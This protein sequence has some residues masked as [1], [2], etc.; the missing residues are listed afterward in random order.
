MAASKFALTGLFL[1]ATSTAFAEE[2]YLDD[3]S[4]PTAVIRSYYNAINSQQYSRA[5]SYR[6]SIDADT[7]FAAQNKAYE[8]F[9]DGFA[10]TKQVTLLTGAVTDDPGAGTYSYS[11]PVAIDALNDDGQHKQFAGCF[12]LVLASPSAQDTVPFRPLYI[13]R[14]DLKPANGPLNKIIPAECDPG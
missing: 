14:A 4:N 5:W 10:Q 12:Y 8:T 13:N 11:V 2:A 6:I 9:R 3:R 7:D 1:L